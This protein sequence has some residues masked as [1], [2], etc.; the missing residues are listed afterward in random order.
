M[1]SISRSMNKMENIQ[2]NN[3]EILYNKYKLI[4]E[5]LSK[6]ANET[7]VNVNRLRIFCS[8]TY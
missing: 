2:K 3:S 7:S 1:F 5:E 4:Y 6:K 8:E